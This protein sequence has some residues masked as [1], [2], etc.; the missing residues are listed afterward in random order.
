LSGSGLCG[1][2]CAG[3]VGGNCVVEEGGFESV[4]NVSV[5]YLFHTGWLE[6]ILLQEISKLAN[7]SIADEDI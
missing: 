2:E 1:E 4:I 7:T 6:S 3:E 5:E